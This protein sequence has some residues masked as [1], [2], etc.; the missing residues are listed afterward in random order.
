MSIKGEFDENLVFPEYKTN[1]KEILEDIL[2]V[3]RSFE[4][5]KILHKF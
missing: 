5:D 2:F 1:L 4:S 3:Y